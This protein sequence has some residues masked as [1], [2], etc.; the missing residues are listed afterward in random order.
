MIGTMPIKNRNSACEGGGA[1]PPSAFF[2]AALRASVVFDGPCGRPPSGGCAFCATP[3]E[4]LKGGG[5][6][7]AGRVGRGRSP[8]AKARAPPG[9]AAARAGRVGRRVEL[10]PPPPPAS[11][12][13]AGPVAPLA[14]QNRPAC[15]TRCCRALS[16][17]LRACTRTAAPLALNAS[18]SACD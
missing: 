11:D 7:A 16:R 13:A 10:D 2:G 5:I 8:L 3:C 6:V 12:S 15:R 1:L 4:I 17:T 18:A 9:H 14:S